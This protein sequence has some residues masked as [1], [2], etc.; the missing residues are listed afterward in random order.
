M[1]KNKFEFRYCTLL[2]AGPYP[3]ESRTKQGTVPEI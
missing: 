1:S 3:V 2:N